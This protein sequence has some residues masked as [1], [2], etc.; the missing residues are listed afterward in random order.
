MEEEFDSYN[1]PSVRRQRKQTGFDMPP[2]VMNPYFMAQTPMALPRQSASV[3]HIPGAELYGGQMAFGGRPR[4]YYG[5]NTSAWAKN[6][7]IMTDP[8][9]NAFQSFGYS[10]PTGFQYQGYMPPTPNTQQS[11]QD[12]SFEAKVSVADTQPSSFTTMN[13]DDANVNVGEFQGNGTQP[14]DMSSVDDKIDE[15]FVSC[16]FLLPCLLN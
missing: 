11:S 2:P 1:S 3:G 10:L 4:S 7:A 9:L 5:D 12:S 16:P 13:A 14:C 8:N 6:A 15:L